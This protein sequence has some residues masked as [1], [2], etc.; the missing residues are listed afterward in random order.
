M[1][2]PHDRPIKSARLIARRLEVSEATVRRWAARGILRA[3][4]VGGL[5]SPLQVSCA[6]IERLKRGAA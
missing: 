6:E 1:Q 3:V 2:T 5:T 4:K